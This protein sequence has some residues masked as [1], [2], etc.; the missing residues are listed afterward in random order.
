MKPARITIV[1]RDGNGV[2]VDA[3][4]ELDWGVNCYEYY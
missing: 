4:G 3:A 1:A 2:H